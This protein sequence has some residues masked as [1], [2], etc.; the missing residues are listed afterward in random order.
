MTPSMIMSFVVA[1]ITLLVSLISIKIG[2]RQI[3][4]EDEAKVTRLALMDNKMQKAEESLS[5]AHDK[6]RELFAKSS[7][8]SVSLA[9]LRITLEE[10]TRVLRQVESA[11]TILSRI[12][13]RINGHIEAEKK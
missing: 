5:H 6:I 3:R 12:E 10:N 8:A 13:E 2:F 7:D 1:A 11:L 9:E 4:T